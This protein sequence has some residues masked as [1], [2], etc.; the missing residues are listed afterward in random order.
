ML[1]GNKEDAQEVVNSSPNN[2]SDYVMSL[3]RYR[4]NFI[5]KQLNSTPKVC[6]PVYNGFIVFREY[7]YIKERKAAMQKEKDKYFQEVTEL[8]RKV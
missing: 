4:G 7:D 1:K 5:V 6:F 8:K 3:K 2:L